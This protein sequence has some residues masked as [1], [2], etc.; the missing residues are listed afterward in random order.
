[1]KLALCEDDARDRTLLR[2]AVMRWAE[3]RGLLVSFFEYDAAERLVEDMEEGV[4]RFDALFLDILLGGMS[5]IDAARRVRAV[6]KRVPLV[7]LTVTPEYALDGYEVRAAGYLVKPLDEARLSKLLDELFEKQSP[8]RL[9]F[10]AGSAWR[11]FDHRDILYVESRNHAAILHTA[12][13]ATHKGYSKLDD[14]E[15]ALDDPRFLR[16]HR[17]YLVNMDQVADVQGDFV[18]HDGSRVPIR[19]KERKRLTEAYYA[20]FVDASCSPS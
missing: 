16:C 11:Y 13:G 2:D 20:Y 5:G 7:F 12:D 9:A 1:M 8:P 6:D 15:A 3:R 10:R 14:V 17:S 19:V 4:E 18:L